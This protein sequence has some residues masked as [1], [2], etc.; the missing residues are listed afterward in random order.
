MSFLTN[1]PGT[2]VFKRRN[3]GETPEEASSV[4]EGFYGDMPIPATQFTTST[5][6]IRSL[7]VQPSVKNSF[8]NASFVDRHDRRGGIV[9]TEGRQLRKERTPQYNKPVYSSEYQKNLIGPL[10]NYVLY[11][12]LYQAG[13]PAAT[14]SL[15][16]NRNLAWSERTP[17]LPTRTTGGPGPAAML[18][19][20]RFK[21][22]QVVP[23]YSTLPPTYP[24]SPTQL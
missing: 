12:G 18:P 7:D 6:N 8:S 17:Q 23:R 19:K 4:Y 1:R 16:T 3:T 24:T 22:V 15:G 13:Y 14:I 5:A 9:Y 20:P 11:P 21:A 10:V 2:Q